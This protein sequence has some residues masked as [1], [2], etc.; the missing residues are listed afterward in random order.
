[1][2]L[3]AALFLL[4]LT[5]ISTAKCTS[6]AQYLKDEPSV[7]AFSQKYIS[8]NTTID[9]LPLL[10]INLTSTIFSKYGY[11]DKALSY[12]SEAL[13]SKNIHIML[14]D[15]YWNEAAKGWQ[16]CP[17]PAADQKST[18][19]SSDKGKDKN[20]S[21][22]K[23][24]IVTTSVAES[25]TSTNKNI[26]YNA[27]N[28]NETQLKSYFVTNFESKNITCSLN[29]TLESV[30]SLIYQNVTKPSF[31]PNMIQLVFNLHSLQSNDTSGYKV[32]TTANLSASFHDIFGTSL[33][34]P[35]DYKLENYQYPTLYDFLYTKSKRIFPM[36]WKNQ[37][38][39]NL[40]V[41]IND[42]Q[43]T[44]F[45]SLTNQ[46]YPKE[47]QTEEISSIPSNFSEAAF[48]TLNSQSWKFWSSTQQ[49]V[50]TTALR[51]VLLKGISI[52]LSIHNTTADTSKH[53][54]INYT[55]INDISWGWQLGQP[56]SQKAAE[57][58]A[59][60]NSYIFSLNNKV[61]KA[62]QCAVIY[63]D[64]WYVENCYNSHIVACQSRSNSLH[65]Q[66]SKSRKTYFQAS[67]SC[68]DK[69]NEQ[70]NFSMP[71]TALMQLYLINYLKE[72]NITD[73]VWIDL[74]TIASTDCWIQG[75]P[76]A[77]CPYRDVDEKTKMSRILAPILVFIVFVVS[78]IIIASSQN[79][80]VQKNRKYWKKLVSDFTENE[81]EGVPA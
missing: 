57:F 32:N 65:W 15:I 75:G 1:M 50:N 18:S 71:K 27:Y 78:L 53:Q 76:D 33:Y 11:T 5:I 80:P 46:F 22:S 81:Y 16:I 43:D 69:E 47:Y 68:V 41:S 40:S 70:F 7:S 31:T 24:D 64:A 21:K 66:L 8:Y 2:T 30:F 56:K 13:D 54:A 34:L 60:H 48:N 35:M 59:T 3:A 62:Y 74:N 37:I 36:I 42:I 73:P 29:F 23:R 72:S 19:K 79:V 49:P 25:N 4:L 45:V 39:A 51:Q 6:P 26:T 44:V 38:S 20:T 28:G 63:K 14:M 67:D 17:A 55:S 61:Q 10:G 58:A 9:K 77:P 52:I 12:I